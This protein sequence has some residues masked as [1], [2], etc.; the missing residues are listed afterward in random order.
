MLSSLP[1]KWIDFLP[2]PLLLN[3]PLKKHWRHEILGDRILYVVGASSF[4]QFV[5]NFRLVLFKKDQRPR[6]NQRAYFGIVIDFWTHSSVFPLSP[7]T[8]SLYIDM[9]MILSLN[10]S[11][12]HWKSS[13]KNFESLRGCPTSWN[14]ANFPLE[15][16][17]HTVDAI[18]FLEVIIL[19]TH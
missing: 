18:Q 16:R 1:L 3:S 8:M 7:H 17:L 4:L 12:S 15:L 11:S 10:C 14:L 2:C 6:G 5:P 9:K 13:I 19:W